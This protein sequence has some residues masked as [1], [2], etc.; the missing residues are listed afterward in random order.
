MLTML[1]VLTQ[2]PAPFDSGV[3]TGDF[4]RPCSRRL[5]SRMMRSRGL[6]V[7]MRRQCSLG[8][9]RY[10]SVSAAL[11]VIHSASLLSFIRPSSATTAAAFAS[12]MTYRIFR[13][14][15]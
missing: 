8:K 7:R 6:L 1:T 15:E 9:A 3:G 5:I 10:A 4:D 14:F 13:E 2:T 11:V 12:A